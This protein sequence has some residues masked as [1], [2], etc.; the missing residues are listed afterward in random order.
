MVL[1]LLVLVDGAARAGQSC[2][3]AAYVAAAWLSSE[4]S[5]PSSEPQSGSGEPVG[6]RDNSMTGACHLLNGRRCL[7]VPLGTTVCRGDVLT[8]FSVHNGMILKY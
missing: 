2:G 6:E 7:Q 1:M 8:G 4:A 5:R 3:V